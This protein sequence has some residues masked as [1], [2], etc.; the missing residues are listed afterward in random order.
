[1]L[2]QREATSAF[3]ISS[4]KNK[5]LGWYVIL[6]LGWYVIS[7]LGWYVISGLG[8]YLISGLGWYVISGL[9]WYLISG[10]GWYVISGLGW[11]GIS[12]FHCGINEVGAVWDIVQ[13]WLAGSYWCSGTAYQ[14]Q[15]THN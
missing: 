5:K 7:G 12:G 2:I 1:M 8:W 14:S 6:G 15:N 3:S 9:G 11:Y 4:D 10:L 13:H